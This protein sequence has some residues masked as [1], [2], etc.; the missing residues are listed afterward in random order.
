MKSFFYTSIFSTLFSF[1]LFAQNFSGEFF[2]ANAEGELILQMKAADNNQFSGTIIDFDKTQYILQ[3][4]LQNGQLVGTI[5][6]NQGGMYFSANQN[7]NQLSLTLVPPDANQQPDLNRSQT[8]TLDARISASNAAP[9]TVLSTSAQTNNQND[10]QRLWAGTFSGSVN[11]V[12]TTMILNQTKNQISG[13]ITADGYKYSL[14]G[15]TNGQQSQGQV[16][17]L[18]TQ[19]TLNFTGQIQADQISLTVGGTEG[20]IQLQ[21]TKGLAKQVNIPVTNASLDQRLIGHWLHSKSYVS[22]DFSMASQLRMILKADGTYLYGDSKVAGGGSSGSFSSDGG[23]MAEGRWK[24]ENK[25]I[26]VND[27]S[28]WVAYANY[29][30]SGNDMMF[31]FDNGEKQMWGRR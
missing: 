20:Q 3:G 5:T 1:N 22:G 4:I 26:Y 18:Q 8:L 14:K 2:I 25:I 10:E 16:V 28:G 21:F 11:G 27:G 9:L 30:I 17:D 19:G 24:T 12:A 29:L 13:T 7:G 6:N 23:D 15:V 31:K